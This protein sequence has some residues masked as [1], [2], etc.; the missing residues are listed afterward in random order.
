MYR[1]KAPLFACTAALLTLLVADVSAAAPL[2]PAD[3]PEPLKPWIPW[4]LQPLVDQ[5]CPYVHATSGERRC[6]WPSALALELGDTRGEFTQK[7]QTYAHGPAALPG[8]DRRWPQDVRVDGQ[9]A[10]VIERDGRP[11]VMLDPGAHEITG[12]FLWDSM[13]EKLPVPAE[14]GLLSLKLRNEAVPFPRRD[15]DGT[16]WLQKRVEAASEQ[17]MVDVVVHRKVRDTI[18]LQV[19]TE[20]SL[21]V[22]GKNREEQLGK[23]LL[24]DFV[25]MEVASELP[26]RLEPD[27][28]LRVQVRPGKWTI[29]VESRH[30]SDVQQLA[31]PI[32][33]GPWAPEEVWVFE[34]VT[35]LRRVELGGLVPVDPQQTQLPDP[36][37]A[38]PAFRAVPGQALTMTVT[39]RGE[40][41]RGTDQLSLTRRWWLDFDG[42]G[43]TVQDEIRGQVQGTRRL[44]MQGSA[45]LGAVAIGGQ[46]QFIT[47]RE[48]PTRAGVELRNPNVQLTA[49]LRVQATGLR[50]TL[51][52]VDWDQDF[53]SVSGTLHLPPGWRVLHAMGIDNV[54]D[55]WLA[56]WTLLDLFMVLVIAIAIARLYGWAWGVLAVVTLALVFPEWMAPRTVWIFA[57]IGEGLVRGLPEGWT[58]RVVSGYRLAALV[59]LA[60]ISAAFAAQQIRQGLHPALEQRGRDDLDLV[61]ATRDMVVKAEP[62]PMVQQAPMD[63]P[64]EEEG[65]FDGEL[66]E[67]PVGGL[68]DQKEAEDGSGRRYK[69]DEGKMGGKYAS[70]DDEEPAYKQKVVVQASSLSSTSAQRQ[71]QQKKLRESDASTVVQTGPGVPRWAWREVRLSWSGP[72][73][74]GQTVSF[75]LVPPHV[76]LALAGVRVLFLAVLLLAVFG[77]FRRRGGGT[78]GRVAGKTT[79]VAGLAAA[80]L[81]PAT[82]RAE[83]P[84]QDQLNELRARLIE[85]P[86]C[87]PGCVTS[88]R[89]RLEAAGAQLRLV[90]EVHAA[91]EVAAPLP[92]SAEHWLPTSVA[93][94]GSPASAG[95]YRSG[96]GTLWV[97]LQP[98]RHELVLEGPLP[99]R[100]NVQLPLPVQPHRVEAGKVEGWTVAG[101]HEDG[102]SDQVLQLTRVSKKEAGPNETLEVGTL[103]PFVRVERSLALGLTWELTTRVVR[104]TP[105]GS[106]VVLKVPLLPGESVTSADQRVEAGAVLVSMKPDQ[107]AAEWTSVLPVADQVVLAAATGVPWSEAWEVLVGPVWHVDASGIPPIRRGAEGLQAWMPWPGEQV[108]LDISR[109]SGVPGSTLTIDGAR[110]SLRPGMRAV[111]AELYLELRTSR[112][113]HHTVAL[114]EG[115]Q[116]QQVTIDGATQPIGQE[117]LQVR[118]PVR[119]GVQRIQLQWREPAT[120][121]R[122]YNA[123]VV[124]LGAAAVNAEVTIEFPQSRWILLLGGPRLGPSVLFWSWIVMLLL[125]STILGRLTISPLRG[126]QWFLLGLGLSTLDVAGAAVVVGWFLLLGWRRQRVDLQPFWFD[127]RQLVIIGWTIAA[128]SALMAAVHAGLLGQPDM[129]IEGNG[130]YGSSLRWYQDRIEYGESMGGLMPRPWV[131]S[132]SLWWYRG[133]MLAWALWLAWSLMRWLPWGWHSVA[134]G[135]L[136]RRA[137]QRPPRLTRRSSSPL[138]QAVSGQTG[139]SQASQS[140][141]TAA[142]FGSQSGMVDPDGPPPTPRPSQPRVSATDTI[143]APP[144]V[145]PTELDAPR[146]RASYAVA[147]VQSGPQPVR[148]IAEDHAPPAGRS[149][150]TPPPLPVRFTPTPIQVSPDDVDDDDDEPSKG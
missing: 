67:A 141:V 78:P 53:A 121:G 7:W 35:V 106:A 19:T 90:V 37:R 9:P 130:S 98:G 87:L 123:P 11:Q 30:P 63:I 92:G 20:I 116:L 47:A 137:W 40:A 81:V 8:D 125:V 65:R 76:N 144:P 16:L 84:T 101:L 33:E 79:I 5:A 66:A 62:A 86:S 70:D 122:R 117:G 52:A 140:G 45:T 110:L 88:P 50:T 32:N 148:P 91:A 28:R 36:W 108:V 74:R 3:V 103:P 59:A 55:T 38:F 105:P 57:L 131:L 142:I 43:L 44:E 6:A 73:E 95:I 46:P 12:V 75:W 48:D 93:V 136:W 68:M 64:A 56:R 127:L 129:Q 104:V 77:V 100:E 107:Y 26:A 128:A 25:P 39:Q 89:M 145:D 18:P 71:R 22:S 10:V 85:A 109:P 115:A 42:R 24:P 60:T 133:L 94:D 72:V 80:L 23:A 118:L 15:N 41:D 102:L 138:Q 13:P 97:A 124:D 49:D 111:D 114:P 21:H 4:V 143:E 34:P 61:N 134:S 58:R 29:R 150:G 135:G 139:H 31:L 99:A 1:P 83:V 82:A 132:V 146:P 149:R 96:D 147:R 14:T 119:P 2:S 51:S 113:G 17:N 126:H 120:L 27:G 54:D 112:G 69:G